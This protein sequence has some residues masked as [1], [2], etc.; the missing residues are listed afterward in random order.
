MRSFSNEWFSPA[1]KAQWKHLFALAGDPHKVLEIGSFEG[2]SACWILDTTD[3]DITCI[4]T[5]EGS[6]E[7]SETEKTDLFTKFS[8]NI[9]EDRDRVTCHKGKSRAILPTL[10]FETFD[11]IYV[12]GDHHAQNVLEDIILSWPLLKK[13]GILVCDDYLWKREGSEVEDTCN[14]KVAID[15][16]IKVFTPHVL[17][18][19]VQC[20]LQRI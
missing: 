13:N 14:P 10:P 3:A 12:D 1:I 9:G 19:G 16:F 5:W 17:S 7:H 6:D 18:T 11:F 8:N 4:D 20:I 2:Q 15:A